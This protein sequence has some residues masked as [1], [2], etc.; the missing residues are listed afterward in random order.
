[1][2]GPELRGHLE[3]ALAFRIVAADNHKDTFT[4][5]ILPTPPRWVM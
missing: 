4:T 3:I 5:P 1:M 2:I